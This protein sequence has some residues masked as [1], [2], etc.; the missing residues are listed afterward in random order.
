M[1]SEDSE[2]LKFMDTLL[3]LGSSGALYPLFV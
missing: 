3:D 2:I 1:K